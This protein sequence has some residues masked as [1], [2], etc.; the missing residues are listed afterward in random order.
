M[1]D[2]LAFDSPKELVGHAREHID[3]LEG[4]INAFFD[5]KPYAKV[6]DFDRETRQQIFKLRITAK[7]PS[8][9]RLIFKDATSNLRD[10]LD[11]AVYASAISLGIDDPEKTGFPFAND[12]AHLQG[13]LGTWKFSD[14]PHDIHPILMS[15]NPYPGGNDLL[16]GLNRMR[17]PNTHRAIVPVAFADLGNSIG[18]AVM[19]VSGGGQFG[20]SRWDATKN[21]VEYMRMGLGSTFKGHVEFAFDVSFGDIEI[22]GGKPVIGTLREVEAEV[23]RVVL[24]LEAE[25][26]R[27]LRERNH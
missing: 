6:M 1:T 8:R 4:A 7:L 10:A 12:A 5:R 18:P 11:H 16:V 24:D 20:Y 17:N 22:V 26:A 13:E 14:V 19:T 25:T 27:I 15:F 21:E 3:R 2:L 9:V 23:S